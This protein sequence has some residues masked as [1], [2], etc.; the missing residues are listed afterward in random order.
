MRAVHVAIGVALARLATLDSWRSRADRHRWRAGGGRHA[1]VRDRQPPPRDRAWTDHFLDQE[2]RAPFSSRENP[3]RDHY[4]CLGRAV[5][6]LEVAWQ[7]RL[8][9]LRRLCGVPSVSPGEILARLDA[10]RMRDTLSAVYCPILTILLTR[11]RGRT[12]VHADREKKK[13]CNLYIHTQSGSSGT[14]RETLQWVSL[15]RFV[16]ILGW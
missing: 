14:R 2:A 16:R 1:G 13:K 6:D 7:G 11:T 4:P 9:G 5:G 12:N 10:S 15:I 8:E 3:E